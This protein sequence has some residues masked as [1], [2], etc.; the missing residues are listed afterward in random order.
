MDSFLLPLIATFLISLGGR[1]QLLVARLAQQL[2]PSRAMLLVAIAVSCLTAAVMAFSGHFIASLLPAKAKAMLVAF[3]LGAAAIE[4][5]WP[6]KPA[7]P[8]EPT[9]SLGAFAL[10]LVY[11]QVGDAARFAIFAFAAATAL[12]PMAGVGGTM[13][14]AAAMFLGWSLGDQ[15]ER[16]LPLRG[17]RIALAFLLA[18]AASVIALSALGI[19]F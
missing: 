11:R 8:S 9:R 12:A 3:A 1:D 19:I 18:I 17:L 13:G 16:R 10:V 14:G 7:K 5:A 2:G 15:I 6:V 4:L